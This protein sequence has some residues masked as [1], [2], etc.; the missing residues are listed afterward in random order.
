LQ[1]AHAIVRT[2][3]MK[4]RT[5][6]ASKVARQ[7]VILRAALE[8]LASSDYGGVTFERVAARAGVNKTTVYR[9][10]PTKAQLVRAALESSTEATRFGPS[11]GSLRGDLLRLGRRMLEFSTSFEGQCV[12]RLRLLDHPEPELAQIARSIHERRMSELAAVLGESVGRGELSADVDPRML[13]ELLGGAIHF[14]L[15]VKSEPVDDVVISRLVDFLIAG[16]T[17]RA[18]AA[19]PTADTPSFTKPRARLR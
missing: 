18:K 3:T 1:V 15:F 13:M 10:W 11:T 9:Q 2:V 16:A 19:R 6:A 12:I 7:G 4:K 5:T 17:P 14:R 8:E